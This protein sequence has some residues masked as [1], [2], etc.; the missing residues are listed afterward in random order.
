[1]PSV[2]P[3]EQPETIS[4]RRPWG[5][6]TQYCLNTPSTVKL[7]E[8]TAGSE[9]SLQRHS[10]RAEL[11]IALD[12]TLQVEVAGRSWNSGRSRRDLDPG[13]RNT[14]SLSSG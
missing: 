7:I 12:D 6:F 1:M 13:R 8:V 3:A 9:L 10:H 4:S 2:P 14:P 5:G 11:W